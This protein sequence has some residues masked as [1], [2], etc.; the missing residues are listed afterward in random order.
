MLEKYVDNFS[1]GWILT[2]YMSRNR[3]RT[4]RS[5][6]IMLR[7][8]IPK[9][10]FYQDKIKRALKKKYPDAF[11]KKIQ[12]GMYSEGGFPDVLCI[13]D[14]HAFAFEVKRPVVGEPSKLQ[15]ETIRKI[16]RAGGT[17]SVVIWPEEAIKII[18]EWE[19]RHD[20]RTG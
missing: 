13:K 2:E 7:K 5:A 6:L 9:E 12:Q 20:Q 14:G 8:A 17:A 4:E 11:V 1:P 18:E 10:S 3:I 15:L 16:K 19:A